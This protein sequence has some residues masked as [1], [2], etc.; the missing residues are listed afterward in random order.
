MR[1][2]AKIFVSLLLISFSASLIAGDGDKKDTKKDAKQ[3]QQ[4]ASVNKGAGM[5]YSTEATRGGELPTELQ[6]AL[7]DM[8]NTSSVG[9]TEVTLPDGTVTVDLQ[10]RFQSA[11]VVSI[12]EDGKLKSSCHSKAPNHNCD[13]HGKKEK[14][15]EDN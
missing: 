13:K 12:G 1:S 10:G 4:T 15:K 7:S 6:D 3:T 14:A 11:M 8:V 2:L 5:V 9:L